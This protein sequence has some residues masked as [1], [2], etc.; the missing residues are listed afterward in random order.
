MN[1][2]E[3]MSLTIYLQTEGRR[4]AAELAAATESKPNLSSGSTQRSQMDASANQR[5]PQS[6]SE[7]LQGMGIATSPNAPHARTNNPRQL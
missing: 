5:Q 1:P 6:L 3:E 4:R 2:Y 7:F